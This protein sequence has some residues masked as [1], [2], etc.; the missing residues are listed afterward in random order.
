[1]PKPDF[2]RCIKRSE[3]TV[4]RKI[5]AGKLVPGPDGT[6]DLQATAELWREKG[7]ASRRDPAL[8]DPL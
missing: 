5:A 7:R 1:M 8:P 6:I 3:R 4:E 2:A